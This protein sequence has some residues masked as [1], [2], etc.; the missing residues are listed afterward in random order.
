[1]A[2]LTLDLVERGDVSFKAEG[3][4]I[5]MQCVTPFSE[6]LAPEGPTPEGKVAMVQ[7]V[8]G[9][10][11]REDCIHLQSFLKDCLPTMSSESSRQFINEWFP[12]IN[13]I[14]RVVLEKLGMYKPLPPNEGMKEG[15]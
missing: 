7:K 6:V 14:M 13:E 9:S 11:R 2:K 3:G 10:I 1:M 5:E 15:D 4:L 8:I 12:L